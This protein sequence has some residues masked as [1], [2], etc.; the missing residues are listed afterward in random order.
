MNE[1]YKQ[2]T[3]LDHF[4]FGRRG[5]WLSIFGLITVFMAF[6]AVTQLRIDA[7]FKK[8]L[9]LQ[10]EYMQTFVQYEEGFGGANRIL[11]A[12]ID[13]RGDMFNREFL[14]TLEAI[15]DEVG[16]MENVDQARV[17]SI[18][19]PNTRYV[20]INE[21]GFDGD[22]VWPSRTPYTF[23]TMASGFDPSP[24][25]MARIR[26]NIVKAGIVG[27]LVAKDFSGAMVQA[28]LI[29]ESAAPG[30]KLD[31]QAVA[32]KLEALRQKYENEHLKVH[33]IGFAKIVGDISD[34]AA[35]VI[36]FFGVAIVL[37]LVLL[38]FYSGSFKMAL[39]PVTCALIA[40]VWTLGGLVLLGYTGIT[41]GGIDPMNI[42]TPFLVFA[43]AVSHG[44]QMLSAWRSELL[45]GGADAEGTKSA[46]VGAQGV[47]PLI[48]AER[49][50]NHLKVP[51][52]TALVTDM[53]GFATI[54][55]I[56]IKIIQEL[57]I[58]ATMGV[59]LAIITTIVVMPL[60]LSYTKPANVPQ[61][62]EKA[63]AGFDR[64]DG[65]WRTLSKLT[66]RVPATIVIVIGL[67]VGYL[68]HEKGKTVMVG[69]AQDGV[70]ELHPDARY[71]IDA[72]EI[73]QR[74]SLSTDIITVIAEVAPQSC[75]NYQP[76]E[77]IDRFSWHM[78]NVEGVSQVISFPGV[79]K[80]LF[81]GFS[82]GNPA[83]RSLPRDPQSMTAFQ[84]Q[85]DT[86]AGLFND[87]CNAIPVM[88]FLEDHKAET[89]DRVVDAVKKYRTENQAYTDPVQFKVMID[90][91]TEKAR[92]QGEEPKYA[93]ANLRL[94]TGNAGVMAATNEQ[95]RASQRPMMF[96]IYGAVILMC[97]ITFRSI[98]AMFAVVLPLVLVTELGNALMVYLGIGLKTNTL[99]V[100]AL[101]V[102]IGV[103]YAIYLYSKLDEF[104]KDGQSLQESYFRALK[105]TGLAVI[106]T[107]LTLTLAVGTWFF[108]ALKFQAD[109]GLMLAFMFLF[110]MIGA[111]LFLPA[112][113]RWLV[114]PTEA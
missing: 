92:A 52:S 23:P 91:L 44:V 79:A 33:I 18:F 99:P 1:D 108:S 101:G 82:E 10:H 70:A 22:N 102:G 14:T 98:G 109:M 93:S 34:G 58:S 57:A 89:I 37:A 32:G 69:D 2:I 30:G 106:V 19:T 6:I 16:R 54:L 38:F 45:F 75:I 61:K 90:E 31:Y 111:I 112:L 62:R 27:R 29:S 73:V 63:I 60:I 4:L 103:D 17:R 100:V 86:S 24:E 95:V 114:R 48:A 36:A 46:L 12:V 26:S 50:F 77:V 7:G 94:A 43:I 53:I 68:A 97:L 5:L 35:S 39:V 21:D 78:R 11:V 55:F 113:C 28:E 110:N 84:Q 104:M 41:G 40:V 105:S 83:F 9:P 65:F 59:G 74:F 87:E 49:A 15:S 96:F 66:A 88:M 80:M 20:D 25:E 81:A 47:D 3:P 64:F 85:L 76:L 42:L 72:A 13:Q 107:A 71:N 67:V 56:P 8:Q 51:G